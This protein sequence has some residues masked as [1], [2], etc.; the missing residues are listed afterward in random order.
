MNERTQFANISKFVQ[1]G[2]ST[3]VQT[4]KQRD[5]NEG[6]LSFLFGPKK[7]TVLVDP[8]KTGN[9]ALNGK[10]PYP[11]GRPTQPKNIPGHAKN[12]AGITR[13]YSTQAV[14]N[15]AKP[16][17]AL[18]NSTGGRPKSGTVN[19]THGWL[20]LLNEYSMAN[21][22]RESN[23]RL[24]LS[25]GSNTRSDHKPPSP[26][27]NGVRKR[28]ESS[29]SPPTKRSESSMSPPTNRRYKVQA[30]SLKAIQQRRDWI[31]NKNNLTKLQSTEPTDIDSVQN[32]K[33]IEQE[34]KKELDDG[35]LINFAEGAHLNPQLLKRDSIGTSLYHINLLRD[36]NSSI[37][38]CLEV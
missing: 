14:P 5:E 21:E 2:D 18:S 28:S 17:G 24:L 12:A 30:R 33:E 19:A 6:F 9:N 10:A 38:A 37:K 1:L 35:E 3:P 32:V 11:R 23:D 7:D 16:K 13:T 20:S 15:N 25:H 31:K 36:S 4:K 34:I 26:T 29:M 8:V 22:S 27:T